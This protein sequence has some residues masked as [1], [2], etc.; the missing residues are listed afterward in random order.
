ML[1]KCNVEEWPGFPQRVRETILNTRRI[2]NVIAHSSG[3]SRLY[4]SYPDGHRRGNMHPLLIDSTPIEINTASEIPPPNDFCEFEVYPK[5]NISLPTYTMW[6]KVLDILRIT[7]YDDD[8]CFLY[9]HHNEVNI[10]R[11]LVRFGIDALFNLV[12]DWKAY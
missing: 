3:G 9:V 5:D 10:P 8:H 7:A 1:L 4:Y 2:N 12:E 6:I 11:F